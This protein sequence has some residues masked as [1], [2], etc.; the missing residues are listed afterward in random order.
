M[1]GSFG[2]VLD[3]WEWQAG[4]Y[5]LKYLNATASSRVVGFGLFWLISV[6][7][8]GPLWFADALLLH[9]SAC[10]HSWALGRSLSVNFNLI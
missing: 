10:A 1:Q 7:K 9:T 2:P 3:V 6:A 5:F 4:R 8:C